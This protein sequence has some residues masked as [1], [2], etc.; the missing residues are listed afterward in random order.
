MVVQDYNTVNRSTW[1]HV[2]VNGTFHHDLLVRIGLHQGSVFSPISWHLPAKRFYHKTIT[3]QDTEL[4]PNLFGKVPWVSLGLARNYYRLYTIFL[5][6]NPKSLKEIQEENEH[7]FKE[8]LLKIMYVYHNAVFT[9]EVIFSTLTYAR[10][11]CF[12][13]THSLMD[14]AGSIRLHNTLQTFSIRIAW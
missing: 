13:V 7:N 11:M 2:R 1:S 5:S 4:P 3:F 10:W 6:L 9:F 8:I 12:N 14:I